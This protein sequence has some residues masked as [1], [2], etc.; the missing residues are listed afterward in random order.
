MREVLTTEKHKLAMKASGMVLRS[1]NSI[2]LTN[3]K[4]TEIRNKLIA[5]MD[6]ASL[7]DDFL[8]KRAN[9]LVTHGIATQ[10]EEGLPDTPLSILIGTAI[11]VYC[12]HVMLETQAEDEI[13]EKLFTFAREKDYKLTEDDLRKE[14]N[15][16]VLAAEAEGCVIR[17]AR[18][19]SSSINAA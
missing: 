13:R 9:N 12:G 14:A 11:C 8:Q 6:D 18:T 15:R 1:P 19:E 7:S 5:M 3:W 4:V 2:Q 10:Y 17:L 16:L